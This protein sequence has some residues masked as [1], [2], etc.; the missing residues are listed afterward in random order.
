[1]NYVSRF[2]SYMSRHKNI[3]ALVAYL[4]LALALTYPLVTQFGDHVPGTTTW[5][6]D[7]YGYVWNNWWF[8]HA[9]FDLGT[10][11]FQTN[12]LF[13]PV[14]TPLVLYTF[15]LLH[16]LLGLPIQFAFG[17]IPASNAELL[18]AFVFNAV[19]MYLLAHYVLRFTFR[20]DN[21]FLVSSAFVAGAIFAFAA[22][23]YVYASLGHYNVVATE[24]MPFYILFFIKTIRESKWKN[25]FLAGLFAAFALYV[26]TTDGVLLALFTFLFLICAWRA[27]WNRAALLRLAVIG[28]TAAVLFA[29][30]LVPTLNEMFNSG[31]TLPGWGHAEKLL[32]D[33]FGFFAPTS[34]Q[35]LTRNWEQEL[36]L[37]RQGIARFSDVNTVFVGYATLALAIL[38]AVRFWKT[39]KVWVVSAIAFAI[40]SLGPLLYIGGKSAFDL[41]GLQVTFP[42]PFLLL[43]Y[44][45]LLKENRVP[46]RFG[47][48][49][50]LSL[51][52]LVAFAVAWTSQKLKGK[53]QKFASLLAFSFLLLIL[54]EHSAVPLP[55]T[56][57]RVPD[58]YAQIARE[59]GNFVVLTL[60][61]GWRN[62]FGQ[63]GAEDTRAQY[64]QSVHQK[65][66]FAAN[67][68]RNAP[69]LF[70]YFDRIPFFHSLAQL[71]A[72]GTVTEEEF[73]LD[74][75]L[76]PQLMSFFDVRY[77]VIQPAI[78]GRPPYSNSRDSVVDYIQKILP[79]GDKVFDRDGVIAY[80]I[81]QPPF[82]D[83]Q[84]VEFGTV[85]AHV[86]QGEGWD[87]DD[88]IAG[89]SANWANRTAARIFLPVRQVADYAVAIRALP[90]AYT[91]NVTQTMQ[92]FVNDQPLGKFDLK[93]IWEEY[94]VTVPASALHAGINDLTLKFDY[95]VRPHDVLA[96]TMYIG[97]T[98][99]ITPADLVVNVS[100]L[101]SIKVNGRE[102][103]PLGRGYNVV[104]I[105]PDTG[106]VVKAQAFNTMDDK[107]Q[108]RAMTEF[109]GA[110]PA[111]Y[112]VVVAS[113]KEFAEN[114]GDRTVEMLHSIGGNIDPR[115]A[116][117]RMHAMIGVKGA[118]PGTAIEDTS[119]D[120]IFLAVGHSP[121]ERTLA[122]A[123]SSITI[124]KK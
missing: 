10:N 96:P 88:S 119:D 74:Q 117:A 67:V 13:Y 116:G 42:M 123:V 77:L 38:G 37:V 55:L 68:Q 95:V 26:E 30:L 92:V 5:S 91:K 21:R 9:I 6:M 40:L 66:A 93:P 25:A 98:G 53:S 51:A 19:G 48:L 80:R 118:P 107:V 121:D 7:E 33:L 97:K 110:V 115:Q 105:D 17:L 2:A 124:E 43:H 106:A 4:L 87:R 14:G 44:I 104:V 32:V 70:D 54:F 114:L 35:P 102:V 84:Y 23:R 72:G 20:S 113:Q 75:V 101:A 29:P 78:P 22:N 52:V 15:T 18:F 86:Y 111:W 94:P 81:N 122:A 73:L 100:D 27:V 112:I 47:V 24:W 69:F 56:D 64:Y 3:L 46:N 103:S 63:L 58:V 57:A 85:E 61:L 60:P 89:E 12:Y 90:F 76:A 120:K 49:V 31:Y 11:P 8:K 59:P 36:A 62:S 1:M 34:L 109:I 71:E 65:Y 79:L 16:V 108:S 28:A 99:G 50:M 83:R 41:D 82:P 39:L 45:P